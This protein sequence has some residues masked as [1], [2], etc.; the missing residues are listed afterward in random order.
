MYSQIHIRT[1]Y[2]GPNIFGK[3]LLQYSSL[4]SSSTKMVNPNRNYDATNDH[5]FVLC[6]ERCVLA[7]VAAAEKEEKENKLQQVPKCTIISL[8][9]SVCAYV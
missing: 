4:F 6:I 8:L 9:L 7:V 5:K 1:Q 2:F 3:Y